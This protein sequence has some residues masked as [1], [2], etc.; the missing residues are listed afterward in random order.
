M[1]EDGLGFYLKEEEW[2]APGGWVPQKYNLTAEKPGMYENCNQEGEH[3]VN[4]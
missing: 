4:D 1:W 3:K 2:T